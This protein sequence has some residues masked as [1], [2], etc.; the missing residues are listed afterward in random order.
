MTTELAVPEKPQRHYTGSQIFPIVAALMFGLSA[1]LWLPVLRATEAPE[2]GDLL[3]GAAILLAAFL[4]G[5]LFP[6]QIEVRRETLLVSGSELPMV[7]GLL[8]LPA[9]TVGLTHVAAGALV[10]LIRRDS[11]RNVAV[12]LSFITVETGT[13]AFVMYLI[14]GP[15]Q[16]LEPT[17][18]RYLAVALGV[19]A[20]ALM[21][22]VAVGLT[23]R[24]LGPAEPLLRVIGRSMLSAGAIVTFA[25]VGYTVWQA[26]PPDSVYG[27]AVCIALAAVLAVLYRTYF[28]FLRQHADLTRMYSFGRQVTNV[29][30]S[31]DDWR[32]VLEQVRDQLNAEVAV[33]RLSDGDSALRTLAIG[34]DGVLAEPPMLEDDPLLSTARTMGRARAS[35]DRS[36]SQGVLA[37]LAERKAWD[38]LVVPLRSGDR[39]RGYLEVRDR[40][41]RWGRFRD[42]DLQLLETLSGHVATAL[43]NLRL[44]ETLRHEAYHDAITGLRNRLGL[45]VEGQAAITAGWGGAILLVEL[46]VLSQVNNALGHD[47]GE[48]LLKMAGERLVTLVGESK[49]VA[50]IEADR[51]AVLVN[52][53]PEL[54]LAALGG[55]ILAAVGRAYSLDGIEVD[56]QAVVGIAFVPGGALDVGPDTG[57]D[58]STLL[59]RAEMAMLAAKAKQEPLQIYRPS[60]GEV[61]RR[62]FQLVTQFRQAVEQG[63]IIV[64]YQPKVDLA[65]RE[66]VG[67][68]AL[69][70][71]MHPEFGLVSPAEFVEAIEATG[72]ID[73]LLGHVLDIV[74][75][76]LS[77]W[78]AQG[79]RLTAAV[80]LSV[81]NLL[82][83]DF[84]MMV[85]KA[86]AKHQVPAELLTFEITESSV[87]ADPEH[88]LPI[89][90][91]LHSM[92]IGLSVDDFGT[93]YSSL[94]Y[95]RRLPIDEI[96]IDRSFVQ[97]MGT[98]LSDLAIVRAIVDLGHS[99]GLRVV[100]EGVE[101]EAARDALREMH[102]D[103]AQ[104]FLISRPMP[105]DRFEAWL[106]ARTVSI[107]DPAST[108]HVLRMMS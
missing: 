98:D 107:Y 41:S 36:P 93:G 87:M 48:R 51:F 8:I 84:S 15:D 67:V 14:V 42:E 50:R 63:R 1:L 22:A 39:D 55:E 20:G 68:E 30:S 43:D 11:W 18:L 28:L 95:L 81:R 106:Q 101:E 34:P 71:W 75:Q 79:I 31:I 12:N 10:F 74:L 58:P 77:D 17:G 40:L 69:V 108:T 44:L 62:R 24:M 86:L 19:L 66:L 60:M 65:E 90:R 49:V 76:Q 82:A 5:E 38:V 3:L 16:W 54:E 33:L 105:L 80:N 96:K 35:T 72:S 27:P 85:S 73:I 13:A 45:H 56:P 92:G 57:L 46:D 37:A 59:Q 23:Y 91:E 7:L 6:L 70:R 100:A 53:M 25:L 89:L 99:L 103:Q 9:W 104:G 102:C 64:H 61:Y 4:A 26:G 21:S 78:T 2:G 47:R 52:A 32:G 83:E 94:A 29:G 97:G 88:S